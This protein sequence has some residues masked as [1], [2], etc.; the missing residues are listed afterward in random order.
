MKEDKRQHL[1][2]VVKGRAI[3]S[4]SPTGITPCQIIDI[5]RQGM[6]FSYNGMGQWG[7]DLLEMDLIDD[8]D[9]YLNKLPIRIVSDCALDDSS[10]A[11][12][13]CGIQF[14]E[15]TPNQQAQLEYF[16]QKNKV[17]IA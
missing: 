7:D 8:E 3:S 13:R 15:L 10:P 5:S 11:L 4:A 16:I 9:F 2:Y 17:G 6:A 14:G 1:R 12:R